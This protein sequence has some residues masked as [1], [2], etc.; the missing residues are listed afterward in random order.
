[1]LGEVLSA[2]WCLCWC[3][4]VPRP[5]KCRPV[6]ATFAICWFHWNAAN[7]IASLRADF[8][9]NRLGNL[10]IFVFRQHI[11]IIFMPYP[12]LNSCLF[13]M[14]VGVHSPVL[15]VNGE[16]HWLCALALALA[17][18]TSLLAAMFSSDL[19]PLFHHRNHRERGRGRRRGL[20]AGSNTMALR[21][22]LCPS[23][24][25]REGGW[26]GWKER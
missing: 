11:M 21:C 1:M 7:F 17:L 15:Q 23:L 22:Y 16:G 3:F 13:W 8:L 25:W 10:C 9:H 19:P 14:C 12:V 5:V 24:C 4:S 26:R 20:K 18:D 6:L 2:C